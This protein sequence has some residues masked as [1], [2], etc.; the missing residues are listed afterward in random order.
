MSAE[1]PVTASSLFGS[2][3]DGGMRMWDWLE[4]MCKGCK[5]ESVKARSDDELDDGPWPVC[6]AYEPRAERSDK[7]L[8]RGPRPAEGQGS[9][10]ERAEVA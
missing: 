6:T 10:F 4:V 8:R 2:N 1:E 9:L 5:R 3:S 7:G